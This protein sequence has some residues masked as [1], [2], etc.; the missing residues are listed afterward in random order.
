MYY[1]HI[2][3]IRCGLYHKC[4]VVQAQALARVVNLDP[5]GSLQIVAS[6]T[7]DSEAVIYNVHSSGPKKL[8]SF[9]VNSLC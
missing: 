4:D 8:K 7:D 6:L 5:R 1:K 3:T 9:G 2:I